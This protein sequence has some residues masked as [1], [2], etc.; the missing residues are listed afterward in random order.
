MRLDNEF[1]RPWFLSPAAFDNQAYPILC[2]F[3]MAAKRA[4]SGIAER[5]C[6]IR[7]LLDIPS[8]KGT[9]REKPMQVAK[10]GT[11]LAV[12]L[13]A[14]FKFDRDEANAR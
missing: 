7:L 5:D 4:S 1:R 14:D 3:R 6:L 12:R 2:R 13:P 11:S 9:S 8:F 10:W